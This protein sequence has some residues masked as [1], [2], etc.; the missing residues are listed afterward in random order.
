MKRCVVSD[1]VSEN[2][3]SPTTCV[4]VCYVVVLCF[5]I[6]VTLRTFGSLTLDRS[7]GFLHCTRVSV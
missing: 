1:S 4:C 2:L 6:V 7:P 5:M 3:P